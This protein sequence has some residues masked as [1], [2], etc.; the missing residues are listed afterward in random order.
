MRKA[1]ILCLGILSSSILFTSC[2]S[3]NSS[4][5]TSQ[6]D[7][8][9]KMS[10]N[11]E[12]KNPLS[13]MN[14]V[15]V[16]LNVNINKVYDYVTSLNMP[17]EIIKKH[18]IIPAP[19][20]IELKTNSWAVAGDTR[21]LFFSDFRN[22][23]STALEEILTLDY[24]NYHSYKVYDFSDPALS[25]LLESILGEWTLE[26]L[27][28]KQTKVTWSYTFFAKNRPSLFAVQLLIGTQFKGFM[29]KVMPRL[30]NKLEAEL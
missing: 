17:A 27:G 5:I 20:K 15:S 8:S 19:E 18:G 16:E 22:A 6:K 7:V 1:L 3:E 24:P 28:P 9:A 14:S 11:L 21:E 23:K 29:G 12:N 25:L 10:N 4:E 26:Q 2:G 13:A 30:K